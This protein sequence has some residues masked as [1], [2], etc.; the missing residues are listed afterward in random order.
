MAGTTIELVEPGVA[1]IRLPKNAKEGGAVIW[2]DDRGVEYNTDARIPSA[3]VAK[4]QAEE[5]GEDW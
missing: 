2:A 4:M 1:V 5:F 3:E